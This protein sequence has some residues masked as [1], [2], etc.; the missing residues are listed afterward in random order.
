MSLSPQNS[1]LF[2]AGGYRR[3]KT[4]K[5]TRLI[6]DI[7]VR[8][9]SLYI[10]KRSRTCDQMVQAAR[11]G[12]QNIIEGSVDAATSR[13]IELKLYTVALGSIT[14]LYADYQDYLRQN[15]V[16]EWTK[17][18]ILYQEFVK[19]KISAATEFREFIAWAESISGGLMH[20]TTIPHKSI[21]VANA[22]LLLINS[23]RYLLKRQIESK[24]ETF[25]Y[26]GGF[27]ERMFQKR[28]SNRKNS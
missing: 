15:N 14:E 27:T 9:V 13:K 25:L 12:V 22:A 8:F 7:T 1:L 19:R 11:S 20:N 17:D 3:L 4:F 21:L 16:P 23:A 24:A 26:D 6:Y 5:L 2:P 10:D 28:N 18:S